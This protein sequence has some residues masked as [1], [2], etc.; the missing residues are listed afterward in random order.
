MINLLIGPPGGGKSYEAVAFHLLPALEQGRKVITNLPLVVPEVLKLYPDAEP[1][2]ELRSETKAVRARPD[3]K[4]A[5]WLYKTLGVPLRQKH[6]V[7]AAFAHAED[8]G[9][10]WRHPET[11]AGPLYIIDE[12]HIPLPRNGTPIAV[13]HWYSLHRHESADVLL[14]TQSYGKINQSIRDLVQICY[15]VRKNTAMGSQNSYIR[16]VQDGIRGEVTN[17]GIRK[18]KAEYFPLYK[19]HTRGGGSELA[20]NDIIPFWKRWPVLGTGLC[21]LLTLFMISTMD[22]GNPLKPKAKHA[23]VSKPNIQHIPPKVLTNPLKEIRHDEIA[24]VEPIKVVATKS[25]KVT[26]PLSGRGIHIVGH[27]TGYMNGHARDVWRF[28][29]SQNGQLSFYL[30][31]EDIQRAGYTFLPLNDCVATLTYMN[32]TRTIACDAPTQ[33]VT[34]GG[35]GKSS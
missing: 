10:P 25:E 11:G 6:F 23:E 30:T 5:Q 28:A 22:F 17:T 14:M 15:R 33:Q 35:V 13:E 31:L 4:K 3:I 34:I 7:S 9:D 24:Q 26:E 29:V 27:I 18:Y 20:A 2:I 8:Y 16:K 1:L 21:L 19:S 32:I 12:C